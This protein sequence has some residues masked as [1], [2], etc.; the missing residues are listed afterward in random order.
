M[1]PCQPLVSF[2]QLEKIITLDDPSVQREQRNFFAQDLIKHFEI[3]FNSLL[4]LCLSRVLV[5]DAQGFM[6]LVGSVEICRESSF[7]LLR[8]RGGRT[9]EGSWFVVR[10]EHFLLYLG[11]W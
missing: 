9:A 10:V 6:F 8:V 2:L 4:C 11:F 5:F 1:Q 3:M 7:D